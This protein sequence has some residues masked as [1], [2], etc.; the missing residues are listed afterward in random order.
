MKRSRI[1]FCFLSG[2]ILL[3]SACA[4]REE[5]AALNEFLLYYPVLQLKEAAGKDAVVSRS[6]VIDAAESMTEKEL[7]E[8]LLRQLFH[9]VADDTVGPPVPPGT[10]LQDLSISG[11]LA[12]V[13]FSSQ[14]TRLSGIELTLAD[15]CVTLTLT[16]IPG[17]NAVSITCDG[18]ALPHRETTLLT[19]ADPLLG[20]S[21]DTLRPIA[22]ALYFRDKETGGLRAEQRVIALFEG[23]S[24]TNAVIDALLGGPEDSTSLEPVLEEGFIVLSTQVEEGICYL[25][26]PSDT[27]FHDGDARQA[28]DSLVASLCSLDFV[29]K[30]QIVLDGELAETFCGVFIKEPLLPIETP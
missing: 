15:Y 27:V 12:Q 22:V 16:Q 20:I 24:R 6:V 4:P 1:L 21:E 2:V 25:N 14:Y 17:V 30:V 19:A 29:E 7:A 11:Q 10:V 28:M 8:E 3:F 13:D 5:N 9:E 23:Q 26:L 18:R